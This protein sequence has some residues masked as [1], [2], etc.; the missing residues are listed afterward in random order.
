M[1]RQLNFIL[2]FLN[3]SRK[4]LKFLI[5]VYIYMETESIYMYINVGRA[6]IGEREIERLFLFS[7]FNGVIV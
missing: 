4:I 3:R 7:I 1:S 5:K 6:R 2:K